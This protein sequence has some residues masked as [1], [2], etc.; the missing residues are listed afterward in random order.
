MLRYISASY[1]SINN[2]FMLTAFIH[3]DTLT[4]CTII[5]PQKKMNIKNE[6]KE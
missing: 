2:L 3:T 1:H 5:H 6:R 4:R